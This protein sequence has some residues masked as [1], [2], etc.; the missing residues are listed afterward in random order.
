MC[1]EAGQSLQTNQRRIRLR[2]VNSAKVR[3]AGPRH[4]AHAGRQP[5]TALDICTQ[6]QGASKEKAM[7]QH[8]GGGGMQMCSSV[9]TCCW[10][11]TAT[12]CGSTWLRV[13]TKPQRHRTQLEHVCVV[14]SVVW[15][16]LR[17][18]DILPHSGMEERLVSHHCLS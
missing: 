14:A 2:S 18:C 1:W 15:L 8:T 7:K 9:A 6:T 17:M 13:H 5:T 10:K 4:E 11:G 16:W 3:G 12:G